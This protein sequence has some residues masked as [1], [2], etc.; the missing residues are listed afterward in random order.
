MRELLLQIDPDY[1]RSVQLLV[2]RAELE[3]LRQERLVSIEVE[4]GNS[5]VAE[6]SARSASSLLVPTEIAIPVA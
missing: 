2:A 6:C 1:Y 3:H 5:P 4:P